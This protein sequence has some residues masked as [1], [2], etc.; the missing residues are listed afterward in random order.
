MNKD[1]LAFEKRTLRDN[2]ARHDRIKGALRQAGSSINALAVE[3]GVAP[4]TITIVSQGHRTSDRIQTELAQK[5]G[6][7]AEKLFPERYRKK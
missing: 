5:L 2:L 3:I 7:T 4:S 6:T 1:S